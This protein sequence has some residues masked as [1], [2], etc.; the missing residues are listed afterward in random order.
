MS[1]TAILTDLTR[2][3]RGVLQ[4]LEGRADDRSLA[5]AVARLTQ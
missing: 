5:G 3:D 2:L 4:H 1:V